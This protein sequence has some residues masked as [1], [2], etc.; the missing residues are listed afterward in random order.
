MTLPRQRPCNDEKTGFKQS[1]GKI[2]D[3][4]Y[5]GRIAFVEQQV[6]PIVIVEGCPHQHIQYR[7]Y[8]YKPHNAQTED[9]MFPVLHFDFTGL[10]PGRTKIINLY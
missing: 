2:Y 7:C 6:C 9:I 10:R 3:K 8:D 5:T 4:L 1:N